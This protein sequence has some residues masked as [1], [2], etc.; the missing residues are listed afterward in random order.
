MSARRNINPVKYAEGLADA[1]TKH[2]GRIFENTRVRK[3]DN[4]EVQPPLCS[5]TDVLCCCSKNDQAT[6]HSVQQQSGYESYSAQKTAGSGAGAREGGN[7][8]Q[9]ITRNIMLRTG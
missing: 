2:G 7:M 4:K 1:I 5:N 9:I 3:F 6:R 8:T